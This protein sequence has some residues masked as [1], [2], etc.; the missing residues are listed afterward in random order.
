[1]ERLRGIIFNVAFFIALGLSLG[2]CAV[3]C[4]DRTILDIDGDGEKNAAT[5]TS[6]MLGYDRYASCRL[7]RDRGGVW[8][9]CGWADSHYQ[10]KMNRDTEPRF[11]AIEWFTQGCPSRTPFRQFLADWVLWPFE[12]LFPWI[13]WILL[14]M[15]IMPRHGEE[16]ESEDP[17]LEVVSN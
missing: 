4:V 6:L 8:W 17:T 13:A 9:Q 10:G 1:M 3:G 12:W 16:H 2:S 11:F 5:I 14:G 7:E 15:A